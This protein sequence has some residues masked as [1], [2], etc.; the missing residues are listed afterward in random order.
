[1]I[2]KQNKKI[3]LTLIVIGVIALSGVT[4]AE[5]RN[6]FFVSVLN[7]DG[8]VFEGKYVDTI[9]SGQIV[10]KIPDN[11]AN[12]RWNG[13]RWIE[14]EFCMN[15]G[16][17]R[18]GK[19][20]DD[21]ASIIS[22]QSGISFSETNKIYSIMGVEEVNIQ[23]LES[24]KSIFEIISDFFLKIMEK[25]NNILDRLSVIEKQLD[26]KNN[27][28]EIDSESTETESEEIENTDESVEEEGVVESTEESSDDSQGQEEESQ[29]ES[30]EDEGE[31]IENTDES[32]EEE[33]AEEDTVEE[34]QEESVEESN[35][36][37]EEENSETDSSETENNQSN[38]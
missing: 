12:P 35:S 31:E 28:A 16:D 14:C 17:S 9:K 8:T 25:I 34:V 2:K 27:Q 19:S 36:Q 6:G 29:E 21:N 4:L 1:M 5:E 38:V 37:E 7:H 15:P 26:I 32:A 10:K 23:S 11:I 3:F 22:R 30:T 33:I 18:F 24:N 13:E 20:F